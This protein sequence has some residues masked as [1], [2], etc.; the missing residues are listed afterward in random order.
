[1]K[2]YAFVNGVVVA[3]DAAGIVL[4]T[5]AMY[6]FSANASTYVGAVSGLTYGATGTVN[7]ATIDMPG[8]IAFGWV[9]LQ[10]SGPGTNPI[11]SPLVTF[12]DPVFT[13]V[14]PLIKWTKAKRLA[15]AG[16]R[17]AK[18][19]FTG[20]STS[21]GVGSRNPG[22]NTQLDNNFMAANYAA[23]MSRLIASTGLKAHRDSCF[24]NGNISPYTVS[25]I[26]TRANE[27]TGWLGNGVASTG[28]FGGT[29]FGNAAAITTGTLDFTPE[30]PVDRFTIIYAGGGTGNVLPTVDGGGSYT[31]IT[32]AGASTLKSATYVI[33][34]QPAI[35]KI[36]FQTTNAVQTY[37][38]GFYAWSSQNPGIL[39]T[40]GGANVATASSIAST[41]GGFGTVNGLTAFA[42][43][44][45]I[46]NCTI[47]DQ[48]LGT[49]LSSYITNMIT[50][51]TAA[52]L[53]GDVVLVINS[54]QAV[55]NFP[56]GTN[57]LGD[58]MT[59]WAV[60]YGAANSINVVD[61]RPFLGYT[62]GATNKNGLSN[63]D[64]LHLNALGYNV[65]C[66]ALLPL[67][68]Q[69]LVVN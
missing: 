46:I 50:H 57:N 54:P 22:T 20:D 1:M 23:Q 64:N 62:Y 39:C 56:N 40:N 44:L 45:T 36:S 29:L 33:P 61:L 17:L 7:V 9:Q 25:L 24:G 26:D 13:P 12:S 47:N 49:T 19:A 15:N 53:S 65:V 58:Q 51:I 60:G 66:K 16:Y 2:H 37:I 21:A 31:A 63:N 38:N 8:A 4:T 11:P 67:I 69:Q 59:A 41:T 43:D 48:Q 42:P 6:P 3:K 18:I 68:L 10:S 32:D 35:H 27:G 5:Y 55:A 52:Q 28:F 34:G 14:Y 30:N